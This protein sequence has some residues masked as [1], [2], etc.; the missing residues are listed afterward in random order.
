MAGAYPAEAW[1]SMLEGI[2][3]FREAT[4]ETCGF[5]YRGSMTTRFIPAT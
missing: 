4:T 5:Q 3:K 2:K 1:S